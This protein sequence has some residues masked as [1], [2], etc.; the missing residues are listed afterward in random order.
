MTNPLIEHVARAS[1]DCWNKHRKLSYTFEDLSSD[2]YEFAILHAKAMIE[3]MRAVPELC[4]DDY[5]C[6][7]QWRSLD[8][9]KVFNLWIDAALKENE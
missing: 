6:D 4:Y 3:S 5:L 2:E 8:S 9:T 7:E 1:F